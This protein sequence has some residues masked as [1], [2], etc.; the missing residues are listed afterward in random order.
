MAGYS[1]DRTYEPG[2]FDIRPCQNCHTDCFPFPHENSP[3]CS[4]C[5]YDAQKE[6]ESSWEAGGSGKGGA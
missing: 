1:L 2:P 6:I 4:S 3:L 5:W